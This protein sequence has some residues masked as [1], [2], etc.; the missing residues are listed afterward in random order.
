ML[1]VVVI[2]IILGLLSLLKDKLS[3][4]FFEIGYFFKQHA[5]FFLSAL[6]VLAAL[7][8]FDPKIA[9][10]LAAVLYCIRAIRRLSIKN[11]ER[12]KPVHAQRLQK[13]MDTKCNH[14]GLQSVESVCKQLPARFH[15]YEYPDSQPIE[16]IIG[17]FLKKCDQRFQS[18]IETGAFEQIKKAGMLYENEL[19]PVVPKGSEKLTHTQPSRV[20]IIYAVS[21]LEKKKKIDRPD[22]D[23]RLIHCVGSIG[24]D[25]FETEDITEE[26]EID[27]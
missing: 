13:W 12:A 5:Y 2:F 9:A 7:L 20:M 17:A 24:G 8:F 25:N 27:I 4:M 19:V 26:I 14:M 16:Y 15:K 11:R 23:K 1:Y 21:S 22:A 6:A 3:D 10:G 18:L